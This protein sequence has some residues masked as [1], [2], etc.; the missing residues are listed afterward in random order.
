MS[1]NFKFPGRGQ[2]D[3]PV[4]DTRTIALFIALLPGRAASAFRKELLENPGCADEYLDAEAILRERGCTQEQLGRLAGEFGKD[5]WLVARSEARQI[6]TKE[7]QFG[8]ETREIKQ[9]RRVAD[10]KLIEDVFQS[11][12][13]RPLWQRV[14]VDDP[15]TAQRQQLLE[16]H[17]RG[18]KRCR[19]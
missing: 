7:K 16:E 17:G 3:T 19:T 14:A 8:P 4:A 10:A 11:F 5:L 15:V 9:Y 12:R 18:R 13:D 1:A 6:P 2:R